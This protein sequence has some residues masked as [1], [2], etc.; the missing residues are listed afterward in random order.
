MA[1]AA[2]SEIAAREQQAA[3]PAA[4]AAEPPRSASRGPNSPQLKRRP[5]QPAEAAAP[6]ATE[7]PP[8]VANLLNDQRPLSELSVEE[9]DHRFKTA[10]QFSRAKKLPDDTKAQLAE[11]S[12]AAREELMAREQAAQTAPAPGAAGNR[13]TA[14]RRRT[15]RTGGRTA[16]GSRASRPS[17]KLSRRGPPADAKQSQQLDGNAAVPAAEAKAQVYLT[18]QRPPTSFPM[19][20]CASGSM[21]SVS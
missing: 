21:A 16:P 2:R 4:P 1:Q 12:K 10:R 15:A 18:I 3:Q 14:A 6:A 13:P 5:R 9:L 7:L 8:D 19:R 17:Q 11:I 20:I